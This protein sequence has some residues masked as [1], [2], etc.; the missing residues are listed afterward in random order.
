[1][2]ILEKMYYVDDRAQKE[3]LTYRNVKW[4]N[5]NAIPIYMINFSL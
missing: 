3:N 2:M 1:M 5:K 4:I